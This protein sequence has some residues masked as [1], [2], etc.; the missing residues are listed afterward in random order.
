MIV[1]LKKTHQYLLEFDS[2]NMALEACIHD[3]W[4]L[5]KGRIQAPELFAVKTNSVEV[6]VVLQPGSMAINPDI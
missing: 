3:N 6:S 2:N 4:V 5:C 1:D